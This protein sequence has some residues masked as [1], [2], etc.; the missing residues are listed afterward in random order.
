MLHPN[1]HN[2]ASSAPTLNA[3]VDAT[4]NSNKQGR[5]KSLRRHGVLPE[6]ADAARR[7][8]QYRH[9][10]CRALPF[11]RD[12]AHQNTL[13]QRHGRSAHLLN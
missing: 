12:G 5:R 13:P 4:R 8:G 2:L 10:S 1:P 6:H 11:A 3:L 9:D 7:R